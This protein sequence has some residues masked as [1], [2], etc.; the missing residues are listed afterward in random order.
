MLLTLQ[1]YIVV[2]LVYHVS[3]T[4]QQ[5]PD[6]MP[7]L[8]S[9][10]SELFTGNETADTAGEGGDAN[11]VKAVDS[12]YLVLYSDRSRLNDAFVERDIGTGV[13]AK[14]DIPKDM[15]LCEYRGPVILASEFHKFKD[16]DKAYNI[17]GLDGRNYKIL[18]DTLCAKINDCTAA[19][20]KPYTLD[21]YR[22]INRTVGVPCFDD[23]EYNAAPLSQ[24]NGKL[25][26]V[27]KRKIKAG[28]EIFYPYSWQYWRLRVSLVHEDIVY[29][30]VPSS[31]NSESYRLKPSKQQPYLEKLRDSEG[32]DL[33]V[34]ALD[35]ASLFNMLGMST[36]PDVRNT[37]ETHD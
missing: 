17:L 14:V 26:I 4:R 12:D 37:S 13:F 21:E 1:I 10:T 18:G 22:V 32:G 3:L 35:S 28:E 23:F 7:D 33:E 29:E 27:S 2:L 15:I 16:F 8:L 31:D 19:M 5:Q 20:A 24:A 6:P 11:E 30:F 36:F 9:I 34:T 25:F